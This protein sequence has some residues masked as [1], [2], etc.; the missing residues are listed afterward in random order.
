MPR[1]RKTSIFARLAL[2][3][4]AFLIG[5]WT[6]STQLSRQE[7]KV[8]MKVPA[9]RQQKAVPVLP[10][11]EPA[12]VTEEEAVGAGPGGPNTQE[13]TPANP[14]HVFF[15]SWYSSLPYD[16]EWAHWD[17][18]F[19]PHW[20]QQVTDRFPKG[21]HVP[22]EDLGSTYYP[23]LGPYSSA[24]PDVIAAQM[25]QIKRAGIGEQT[26][27]STQRKILSPASQP[28]AIGEE[29]PTQLCY[30]VRLPR[31][32]RLRN[33]QSPRKRTHRCSCHVVVPR[34]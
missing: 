34:G 27:C 4:V 7:Q 1:V 33:S 22:P 18:I 26:L 9:L 28:G 14:V 8:M 17:H 6:L 3:A 12:A 5:V 2:A 21:K 15:Y 19:M 16:G 13:V 20:T 31:E 24:N 10:V 25:E 11:V 29:R 23:R 30:K 32:G